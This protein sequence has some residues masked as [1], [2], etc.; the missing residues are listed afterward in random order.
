MEGLTQGGVVAEEKGS[1]PLQE[2]KVNKDLGKGKKK[3]KGG[4]W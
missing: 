3:A 1:T 4:K 2:K